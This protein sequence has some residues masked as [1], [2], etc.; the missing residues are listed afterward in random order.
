[1]VILRHG[2]PIRQKRASR[3][4]ATS[5]SSLSGQANVE[6]PAQ[7]RRWE[8][9]TPVS[10][11]VIEEGTQHHAKSSGSFYDSQRR[12]SSFATDCHE[13]STATPSPYIPTK[14]KRYW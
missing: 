1:M 5:S 3:V 7:E 9:R 4:S 11:D 13:D 12:G 8:V 10:F 2:V 14:V 6:L